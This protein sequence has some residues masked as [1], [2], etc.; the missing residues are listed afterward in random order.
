ML[1]RN[2]HDLVNLQR[3]RKRTLLGVSAS[4]RHPCDVQ[5]VRKG[6]K[7][8]RP[9]NA[10]VSHIAIVDLGEDAIEDVAQEMATEARH[11]G[12]TTPVA[13]HD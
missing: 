4:E 5:W 10:E 7:G 13:A 9:H 8:L 11:D 1:R 3:H 6:T 2:E 12:F